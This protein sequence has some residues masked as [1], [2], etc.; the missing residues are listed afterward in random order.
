VYTSRKLESKMEI[1]IDDSLAAVRS[2]LA[3]NISV[4]GEGK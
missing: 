1:P 2:V 4:G 3:E